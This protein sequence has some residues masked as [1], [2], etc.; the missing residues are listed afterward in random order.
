MPCCR[1]VLLSV[2]LVQRML[3]ARH[4]KR[5]GCCALVELQV[6]VNQKG[7]VALES[8]YPYSGLS[9]G[10]CHFNQSNAGANP[11]FRAFLPQE[12][13][14]RDGG[15]GTE[16]GRDRRREGALPH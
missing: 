1:F 3:E 11:P 10:T 6:A 7:W 16:L 8:T 2:L 5:R 9:K 4:G 14:V 15:R 13:R 12:T